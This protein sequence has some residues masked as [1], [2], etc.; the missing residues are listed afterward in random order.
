ME[1][2]FGSRIKEVLSD[3][4]LTQKWVAKT[5]QTTEA[6]IS[7]YISGKN[8]P[9]IIDLLPKIASALGVST[10]FLLGMSSISNP[11]IQLRPDEQILVACF[12]K[13]SND[14][15]DVLWSVLKKY[16][17]PSEKEYLAKRQKIEKIG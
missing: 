15:I 9:E 5:V 17:N 16:M 7:R 3:N 8:H 13:A 11:Q 6:T 12:R 4:G 1:N 14:D 10:D 2:I